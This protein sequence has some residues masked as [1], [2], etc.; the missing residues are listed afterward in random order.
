MLFCSFVVCCF[1]FVDCRSPVVVFCCVVGGFWSGMCVVCCLS[2]VVWRVLRV[3]GW[4]LCVFCFFLFFFLPVGLRCVLF[5]M[6]CLSELL[7]VGCWLLCGVCCLLCV[8]R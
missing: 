8:V 7:V 6:F 1:V 2:V 4:M 5:V 3:I